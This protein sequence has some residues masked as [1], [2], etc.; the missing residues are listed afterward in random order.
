MS[1]TWRAAPEPKPEQ[2]PF[3]GWVRIMLRLVAMVSVLMVGLVVFLVLRLVE[4]PIWRQQRPLTPRVTVLV[5]RMLLG[6]IGL[7]LRVGGS[8]LQGPGAVVANHSSWLDIL[9]LNATQPVYFV[10]K[11]EV[12]GWPGIGL[13]ARVTGTVFLRRQRQDAQLQL[14]VFE[15]RLVAGHRLLFFPEGTSTDGTVVLPF[16]ST[17]FAAFFAGKLRVELPIQPLSVSYLAP[18]KQRADFYGW[19]GD[20]ALGPHLFKVLAVRRQGAVQ[21]TMHPPLTVMDH[22]DRK[23]LALACETAV[24]AGVERDRKEAIVTRGG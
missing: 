10:A 7:R 22:T 6:I 3:L 18:A 15:N 2:I 17:L 12:A 16:K 11:S 8:P 21:L 19:W 14:A 9:V 5:C 4:A 1:P 23:A 24:R 13:L 20:M